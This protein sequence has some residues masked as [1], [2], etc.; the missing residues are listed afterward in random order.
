M[1]ALF[2]T[3]LLLILS[4]PMNASAAICVGYTDYDSTKCKI[5]LC[6][7]RPG[8]LSTSKCHSPL[9][10]M[11]WRA[12]WGQP[13][14]PLPPSECG[15][16]WI[17]PLLIPTDQYGIPLSASKD[18]SIGITPITKVSSDLATKYAQASENDP[19]GV[20]VFE[21][22]NKN[23]ISNEK[24]V[25]EPA[26][27]LTPSEKNALATEIMS[28]QDDFFTTCNQNTFQRAGRSVS[29]YIATQNSRTDIMM[30]HSS[31]GGGLFSRKR[32]RY[33][34]R[35]LTRSL[36]NSNPST[37]IRMLIDDENM[38]YCQRFEGGRA[39][40]NTSCGVDNLNGVVRTN[41]GVVDPTTP[42]TPFDTPGVVIQ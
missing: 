8:G 17:P 32:H 23:D 34:Y 33:D 18:S 5:P 16:N 15:C 6:A 39:V 36:D 14:I 29:C 4:I 28:S 2:A 38:T 42:S 1:R 20:M 10:L 40:T 3:I 37:E 13:P 26:K 41:P 19:N 9:A 31:Y 27:P 11:A 7:L 25:A 22:G 35:I 12:F 21:Q 30:Q 24:V